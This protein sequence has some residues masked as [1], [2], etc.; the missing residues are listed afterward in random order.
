MAMLVPVAGDY[1]G[2][3]VNRRNLPPLPKHLKN[4]D[5]KRFPPIYVFN[6]GPRRHEFEALSHGARFL[7]PCPKGQEYSEPLVM[8]DI[9]CQPY[10]LADGAGNMAWWQEEGYEKACALVG[11]TKD[12]AEPTLYTANLKWF[13]VFITHNQ[14]PTQ[15]EVSDAKECLQRMMELIYATGSDLVSQNVNVRPE[16]RRI[17]NEAA[18]F[19]GHKQLYGTSAHMMATC[20]IC[21]N[22]IIAGAKKCTHCNEML[23]PENIKKFA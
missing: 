7:E 16:D 15:K 20:P 10:D 22:S 2:A 21:K 4:Q 8:Q 13:G 1:N 19:L 9:E 3:E 12:E 14:K 5:P 23:T 6:V 17:Y 11:I 18:Q